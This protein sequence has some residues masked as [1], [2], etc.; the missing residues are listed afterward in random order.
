MT[1]ADLHFTSQLLQFDHSAYS[2]PCSLVLVSISN[3]GSCPWAGIAYCC[4]LLNV[5]YHQISLSC[6]LV[7]DLDLRHCVATWWLTCV[8]ATWW[9]SGTPVPLVA[10]LQHP[11]TVCN[12]IHYVTGPNLHGAGVRCLVSCLDDPW[13]SEWLAETVWMLALTLPL[14][15]Y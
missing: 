1:Y 13:S 15:W 5:A 2:V 3:T 8:L 10:W 12:H 11:V 9:L 6:H 4:H 14:V 7:Y